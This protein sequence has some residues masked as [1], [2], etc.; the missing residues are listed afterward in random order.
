V[1]LAPRAKGGFLKILRARLWQSWLVSSLALVASAALAQDA[2]SPA[3]TDPVG[4][5]P[6]TT[7]PTASDNS[8]AA[9]G[10]VGSPSDS[11]TPSGTAP[12]TGDA[13]TAP[14]AVERPAQDV[15]PPVAEPPLE[16]RPSTRHLSPGYERWDNALDVEFTDL[17]HA[18]AANVTAPTLMLTA[19]WNY[20]FRTA[21]YIGLTLSGLPQTLK[22]DRDGITN[23]YSTYY[24]GLRVGQWLLDRDPFR[25]SVSFSANTGILYVRTSPDDAASPAIIGA[26]KYNAYE[27]NF[28]FTFYYWHG[29]DFGIVGSYRVVTLT[30][31]T[32]QAKASDLSSPAFGLTF[33]SHGQ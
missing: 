23:T 13:A 11:V 22:E 5:A 26:V 12:G 9:D 30:S 28:F 6:A 14:S 10:A 33:R 32:S 19:E 15:T 7:A 29:L 24:G 2:S 1:N 16:F 18:K 27:P 31:S 3:T 17:F 20:L 21:T 25:L 4:T 8:G